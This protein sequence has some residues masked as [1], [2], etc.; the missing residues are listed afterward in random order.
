MKL[1]IASRIGAKKNENRAIRRA[2]DIPAVI[3]QRD[4]EGE[5]V[6]ING[7]EFSAV[8]RKIAPGRLSTTLFDLESEQGSKRVLVKAIQYNPT[9][10]HVIH[11]DFEELVDTI[12]INVN[13]PI[14]C[15]GIVDSVGIKLGGVLRQVIRSL[16]VRCLPK[17]LPAFF[18]IDIRNL[19]IFESK[20]LKDLNIP[21]NVRPLADINEVALLIA[22]R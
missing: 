12:P 1:K 18:Q 9:N 6:T 21:E 17:D 10:Y 4:K 11:L 15:V 14:E 5:M 13:V 2:G 19:G 22:K 3:Y 7:I 20:K 16:K 8:L